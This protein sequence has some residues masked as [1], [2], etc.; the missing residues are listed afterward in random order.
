[1]MSFITQ[2]NIKKDKIKSILSDLNIRVHLNLLCW[3]PKSVTNKLECVIL[4]KGFQKGV[5]A[6]IFTNVALLPGPRE[7]RGR[8]KIY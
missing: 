8:R 5:L 7:V 4:K 2:S 6:Y 3:W 1:M